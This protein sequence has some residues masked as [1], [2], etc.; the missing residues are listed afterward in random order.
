MLLQVYITL[1]G[2][3]SHHC[4]A[5][6]ETASSCP[7]VQGPAILETLTLTLPPPEVH[8]SAQI[9]LK[10]GQRN[11]CSY[12]WLLLLYSA[13]ALGSARSLPL[14]KNSEEVYPPHKAQPP[15][16]CILFFLGLDGKHFFVPHEKASFPRAGC[17][18]L[19]AASVIALLAPASSRAQRTSEKWSGKVKPGCH[20]KKKTETNVKQP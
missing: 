20:R 12:Q 19:S 15:G 18:G 10:L 14:A 5:L 11:I 13:S 1:P 3:S 4:M 8:S 2:P 16:S 17:A 9:H 7:Q 6:M